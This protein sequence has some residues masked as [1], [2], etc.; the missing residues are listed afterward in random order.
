MFV[1]GP[2]CALNEM[3]VCAPPLPNY[4]EW[5]REIS[6]RKERKMLGRAGIEDKSDGQRL[7]RK[8]K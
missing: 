3:N 2:V 5:R 4:S 6:G 1:C 7:E 8:M